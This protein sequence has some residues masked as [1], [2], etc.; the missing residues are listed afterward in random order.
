MANDFNEIIDALSGG[1]YQLGNAVIKKNT[2]D[3]LREVF[4]AGKQE[5]M[6][7]F[8]P[9]Q[10]IQQGQTP[11]G[12][13]F[14]Q[15]TNEYN[16][17]AGIESV[18]NT[19]SKIIPYGKEGE[20]YIDMIENIFKVNQPKTPEYDIREVNGQ[21]VQI[22]KKNPANNKV[23][24]GEP[25]K[26]KPVYNQKFYEGLTPETIKDLTPDQIKEGYF[27]LPKELQDNLYSSNQQI[28]DFVDN[29]LNQGDYEKS[30]KTGGL[31]HSRG[32]GK[33]P[34]ISFGLKDDKGDFDK[35]KDL[36]ERVWSG[37]Q[38]T[39]TETENY[40]VLQTKLGQK[41]NLDYEQLAKVTEKLQNAT[42]P[43]EQNKIM[44]QLQKG[45]YHNADE[46][47]SQAQIDYDA[48]RIN[49]WVD[50]LDQIANSEGYGEQWNIQK[51]NF[52][53]ELKSYFDRGSI[54]LKEYKNYL[55]SYK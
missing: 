2:S 46:N 26:E 48:E 21:L 20:P 55:E 44:E 29:T 11:Q 37:E 39:D 14:E 45:D 3:D 10:N 27:F 5:L 32:P 4:N 34:P 9:Q 19:I 15:K 35:L 30:I 54:T 24:Y 1:A 49:Q 22:D 51:Q 28:K 52:K 36:N 38:L 16:P 25:K 50:Y 18:Y 17:Q 8:M 42:T 23:V 31:R 43:K 7:S 40:K 41:Y 12:G 47:T 6:K 53:N 13:M 33:L